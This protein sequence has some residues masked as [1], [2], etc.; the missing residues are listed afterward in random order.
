MTLKNCDVLPLLEVGLNDSSGSS[1][2]LTESPSIRWRLLN[3]SS[4]GQTLTPPLT[5]PGA[6]H[7]LRLGRC[8]AKPHI[9]NP[10]L[11]FKPTPAP[12]QQFKN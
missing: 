6:R 10:H 5:C 4:S 12:W 8:N 9:L 2:R 1:A 3:S 11:P 7:S